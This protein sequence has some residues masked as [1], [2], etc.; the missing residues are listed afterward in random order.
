MMLPVF[1]D[2]LPIYLIFDAQPQFEVCIVWLSTY[3]GPESLD[4]LPL[5]TIKVPNALKIC[6]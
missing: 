1:L 5:A 6:K 4:L 3:R 2:R